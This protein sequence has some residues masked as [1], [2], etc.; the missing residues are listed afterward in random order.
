MVG[1]W[2]FWRDK[3]RGDSPLGEASLALYSIAT[4]KDSWV[5]KVWEQEGESGGWNS[6]F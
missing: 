3:W 4:T 6:R 2:N 5:A 1:A